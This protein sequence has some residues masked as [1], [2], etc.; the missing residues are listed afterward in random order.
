MIMRFFGVMMLVRMFMF[1]RM[2]VM[3]L[4]R[5]FM[6][7]VIIFVFMSMFFVTVFLMCEMHREVSSRYAFFQTSLYLNFEFVEMYFV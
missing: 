6:M 3:V 2:I 1:V 4:M 7:I 5:V